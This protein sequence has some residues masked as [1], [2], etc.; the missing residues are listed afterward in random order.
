MEAIA[1][2]KEQ[3]IERTDIKDTPFVIITTRGKSFGTMGSYR[4]TEEYD[5]K[6]EVSQE[7]KKITWNRIVQVME[8][9]TEL[10]KA[11]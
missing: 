4:I 8:I 7:L 5:T 2:K 3:L 10:N 1:E 9:L 11:R 6:K